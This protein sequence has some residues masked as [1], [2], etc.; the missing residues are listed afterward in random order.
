MAIGP[1]ELQGTMMRTQDFTQLKHQEDTRG[2]VD[3]SHFQDQLKKEVDDRSY[4]VG[5]KDRAENQMKK[6]DAKDKGANEYHR[7]DKDKKKKKDEMP[8]Q[9]RGVLKQPGGFDVSI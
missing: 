3:Q 5:S 8:E 6:F 9:G 2:L 7:Q 1:I 4:Q